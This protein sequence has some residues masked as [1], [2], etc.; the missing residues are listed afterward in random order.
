MVR[1]IT[2]V[3]MVITYLFGVGIAPLMNIWNVD[4]MIGG[5]PCFFIGLW[6]VAGLLVLESLFLYIYEK[7]DDTVN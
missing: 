3:I 4:K 1:K 7:N 2:V 5:I 6:I